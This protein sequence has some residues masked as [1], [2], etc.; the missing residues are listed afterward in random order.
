VAYRQAACFF[1][2]A[3]KR[4]LIRVKSRKRAKKLAAGSW[5][6]GQDKKD[7]MKNYRANKKK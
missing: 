6:K 4:E 3:A 2:A 7:A 1:E 5:K